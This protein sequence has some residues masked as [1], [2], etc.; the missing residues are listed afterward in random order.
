MTRVP[1]LALFLFAG[2]MVFA[3]TQFPW[4][5]NVL[6]TPICLLPALVVYTILTHG[7]GTLALFAFWMGL[8]LDALSSNPMGTS[9]L[10]LFLVGFLL[11]LRR[12]LILRDQAYAQ[13]WLGFAASIAL[14]ALTWTVLHLNGR[15]PITGPWT[16]WQVLISA[17]L[18]GTICPLLF[19]FFDALRNTFDYQ[20]LTE[21]S[22]RP[23]REIKRGRT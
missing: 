5:A 21:G 23:D 6:G 22:F 7:M 3:Q 18:N 17:I 12:H 13:F 20:P 15:N 2:G 11:H 19:V 8:G 4:I 16:L 1:T 14:H 10:P 9:I